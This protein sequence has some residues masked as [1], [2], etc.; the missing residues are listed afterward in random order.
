ME[1]TD[2]LEAL[3]DSASRECINPENVRKAGANL[4]IGIRYSI[5]QMLT[6]QTFLP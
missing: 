2:T 5:H 6:D 4:G 1:I 3:C